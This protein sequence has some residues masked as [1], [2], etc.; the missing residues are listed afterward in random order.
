MLYVDPST[1]VVGLSLRNY[2]LEPGTTVEPYS[3]DRIGEV[4]EN[5]RI[6]AS[7]HMSGAL[8]ELPDQTVA[9]VHVSLH[10]LSDLAFL[11]EEDAYGDIMCGLCRGTT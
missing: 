1:R 11:R 8:L 3:V 4:V 6:S 9:F 10:T 2:L 5:C 7:H